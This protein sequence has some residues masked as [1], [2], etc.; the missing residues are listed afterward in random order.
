MFGLS[1]PAAGPVDKRLYY[2][3][4]HFFGGDSHQFQT[5]MGWKRFDWSPQVSLREGFTTT[6]AYLRMI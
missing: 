1:Q 6:A 5:A 3:G 4:Y 2:K